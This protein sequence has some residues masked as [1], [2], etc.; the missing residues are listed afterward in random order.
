M[1]GVLAIALLLYFGRYFTIAAMFMLLIVASVFV[2]MRLLKMKVHIVEWA[3]EQFERTGVL[4]PGW[5]AASY[6][7]GMLISLTFLTDINQIA[8]SIF[9]LA[10]GDS[11]STIVGKRGKIRLP[12]NNNKTLEGSV[13][14]F[15]SS[16]PAYY[17]VGF[18]VV[19]LALITAIVESVS[20]EIDDNLTIPVACTIF[21]L[22]L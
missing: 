9:I 3:E 5:G 13:A 6:L 11:L 22:V 12:H 19:P 8:A 16:L 15:I 20:F 18:L 21:F 2:N 17:F 1:V 10:V 14:F 4:F 7:T